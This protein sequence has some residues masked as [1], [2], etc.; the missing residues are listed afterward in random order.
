MLWS[1]VGRYRWTRVLLLVERG[2]DATLG[3]GRLRPEWG[4]R[5]GRAELLLRVGWWWIT[6]GPSWGRDRSLS[7]GSRWWGRRS[8]SKRPLLMLIPNGWLWRVR[9]L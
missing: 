2:A 5:R 1:K 3:V 6:L 8:S 7:R 9:R 4:G